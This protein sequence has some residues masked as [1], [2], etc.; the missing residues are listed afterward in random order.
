MLDVAMQVAM[1]NLGNLA[2]NIFSFKKKPL[3]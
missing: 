2:K 3:R 1:H